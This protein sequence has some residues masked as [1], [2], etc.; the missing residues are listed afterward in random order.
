VRCQCVGPT[1]PRSLLTVDGGDA[2]QVSAVVLNVTSP[3]QIRRNDFGSKTVVTPLKWDV[4]ITLARGLKSD[5]APC[6]KRVN[7]VGLALCQL[8]PVFPKQRTSRGQASAGKRQ[9]SDKG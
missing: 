9:L 8:L 7:R 6:L 4:C 3:G 1:I 2:D 5:I